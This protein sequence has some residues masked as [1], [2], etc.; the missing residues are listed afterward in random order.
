V[1]KTY[2]QKIK[3]SLNANLV[4]HQR[5]AGMDGDNSTVSQRGDFFFAIFLNFFYNPSSAGDEKQ[6]QASFRLLQRH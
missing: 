5:V 6:I 2:F 3:K 4:G 1:P